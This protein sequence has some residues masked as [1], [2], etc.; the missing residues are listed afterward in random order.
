MLDI[1]NRPYVCSLLQGMVDVREEKM[2]HSKS[3]DVPEDQ[4]VS[5]VEPTIK[6]GDAIERSDLTYEEGNEAEWAAAQKYLHRNGLIIVEGGPDQD[7]LYSSMRFT[8]SEAVNRGKNL[9]G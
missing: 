9:L 4:D 1:D 5:Y 8:G 6:I 3:L 2:E 7:G